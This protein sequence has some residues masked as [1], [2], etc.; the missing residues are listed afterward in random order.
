MGGG[1][2]LINYITSLAETS[3]DLIY[4]G[5]SDNNLRYVGVNP[6]N[7]VKFNNE[8][9]R[10]M[11]VMNNIQDSSGVSQS[12][13]KL[14]NANGIGV[15]AWDNKPSGTGTSL[16]GN[17]SNDWRDSALQIILNSGAY[18]N[19]T[20]GPCPLGQNN[21]TTPC[22]FSNN[23]LTEESKKMITSVVWNL[24]GG[25]LGETPKQFYTAERATKV[26][27]GRP[28]IWTGKVGLMYPSDYGYATNGGADI[29]LEPCR[30]ASFT[31]W[32][33][34]GYSS[35]RGYDWLFNDS[36]YLYTLTPTATVYSDH[37][38]SLRNDGQVNVLAVAGIAQVDPVVF[39]DT[40]VEVIGNG[41]GSQEHP[42]ELKLGS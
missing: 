38:F 21:A 6:N 13:I 11:G 40:S 22:D 20:S 10:I 14:I 35:C 42:F 36:Q 2:N 33:N 1:F 24:G 41:D 37:V 12:R 28:T 9:W 16:S 4:D 32:Q 7:Y 34:D 26:Y 39:L 3:E 19:R 29:Y 23:G 27:N 17:G 18:Y 31:Q 30:N 15:Y 8:L 5:T 25:T